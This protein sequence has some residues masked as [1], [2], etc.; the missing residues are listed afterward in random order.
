L[1]LTFLNE[2]VLGLGIGS[3]GLGVGLDSLT[4]ASLS[5][6]LHICIYLQILLQ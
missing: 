3:Q 2:Q 5:C 6:S 1:V 4:V